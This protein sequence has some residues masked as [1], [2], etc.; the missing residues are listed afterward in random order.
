MIA[1]E[2]AVVL[3]LGDAYPAVCPAK[4]GK[5]KVKRAVAEQ[6]YRMLSLDE[7]DAAAAVSSGEMGEM[8]KTS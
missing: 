4:Q 3:R 2:W 1:G 6:K 8:V 7:G 5:V